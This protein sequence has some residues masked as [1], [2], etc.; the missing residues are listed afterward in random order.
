MRCGTSE[1]RNALQHNDL[2]LYANCMPDRKALSPNDLQLYALTGVCYS[3]YMPQTYKMLRIPEDIHTMLSTL[4][5]R[6]NRSL[7]GTLR[8]VLSQ[9]LSA[10]PNVLVD[11]PIEELPLTVAET[12]P[13][14][15]T[16][17]TKKPFVIQRSPTKA[18]HGDPASDHYK[19][20]WDESETMA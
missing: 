16:P 10:Q 20:R 14:P 17:A 5:E 7:I 9:A 13:Q 19:P 1:F 4:A 2:Q 11:K 15:L 6:D 12:T 18:V 3:A 8:T